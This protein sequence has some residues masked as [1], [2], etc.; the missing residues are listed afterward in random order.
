LIFPS[1]Q[2]LLNETLICKRISTDHRG[3]A[4][5]MPIRV[6]FTDVAVKVTGSNTWVDAK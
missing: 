2:L 6:F 4:D 3:F 1:R 5:G